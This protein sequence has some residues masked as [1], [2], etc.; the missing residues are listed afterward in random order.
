MFLAFTDGAPGSDGY[1]DS[2]IFVVS[3]YGAAPDAT[4]QPGGLYKIV[5][6]SQDGAGTTFRWKRFLQGGEA[7]SV[8]GTGFAALDNMA[9]DPKGNIL[10]VTDMST[11]LHNGFVTG[12]EAKPTEINHAAVPDFFIH[13]G[14]QIYGDNPIK[15][16]VT[17][18]D[19]TVWRNLMTGAK[20]KVAETLDEFRGNF[21]YN[22][23]DENMRRFAAEVPF[24][25]QW[26]DHEARNNWYPGRR[27]AIPATQC[28]A[29][30][31]WPRSPSARW[32]STARSGSISSI[33]SGC[34]ERSAT[35][36]RSTCS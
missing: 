25:V 18:D 13:S 19:G 33:P 29:R 23:L 26:D 36:R 12:A 1:P 34:I 15:P 14:D 16:E 24:L 20:S 30:R 2:R 9:F 3:K 6:D 5:E 32:S 21:A 8:A 22:L 11:G 31:S 35:G 7:G 17:L 10:G 27:S 4:Q 28:G